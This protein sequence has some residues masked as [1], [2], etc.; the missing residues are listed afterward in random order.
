M[1]L[2]HN[3]QN[4]S[5]F[6]KSKENEFSSLLLNTF[7]GICKQSSKTQDM[8]EHIDLIWKYNNKIVTFD[9]KSAKKLHRSDSLPNYNINWIE[10]QNVRGNKGWLFG[11]A[12]YIAFECLKDW[13]IVR[14]TDIINLINSKVTNQSISKS[15]D[16]YT[17]Y[18]RDN[19]QDIVVKVPMNDLRIIAK[20]IINKNYL[21]GK[22]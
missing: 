11:E 14:R 10:L 9:V 12:D 20:K 18:Q 3:W 21:H 8:Y 19:R 5:K 4:L 2:K 7:G 6:G 13:L 22:T 1:N 17:Y 15:K 16:F